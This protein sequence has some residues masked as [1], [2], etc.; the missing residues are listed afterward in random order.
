MPVTSGQVYKAV[1]PVIRDHW[2]TG[3]REEEKGAKRALDYFMNVEDTDQPIMDVQEWG[4]PGTA[5]YK[6]E[7]S[8]IVT[9]MI[10]Q[11]TGKRFVAQTYAGGMEISYEAA[12]DAAKNLPVIKSAG[13]ML[14]EMAWKT[15][16]YLAALFMDRSFNSSYAAFGNGTPL[17]STAQV[18]P[19]GGTF[20]NMFAGAGFSLS[21]YAIEQLHVTFPTLPNSSGLISPDLKLSKILVHPANVPTAWKLANTQLQVGSGNNNLSFVYGSFEVIANPFLGSSTR[22]WG[23]TNVNDDGD[24]LNWRWRVKPEFQTDNE[25]LLTYK[26][27]VTRFRAFWFCKNPRALYGSNAV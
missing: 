5:S 15:P 4:G 14:G 21:E 7:G 13:K 6:A 10:Y 8:R 2:G 26:V 20:S 19:R 3:A 23:L 27:Y 24:G 18:L 1:E 12:E 11:G 9:D 17:C 16:D 22:W 25:A